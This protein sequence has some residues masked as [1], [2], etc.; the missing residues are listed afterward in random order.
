MARSRALDRLVLESPV[1]SVKTVSR[2][3]SA[4]A[5]AFIRRTKTRIPP[6]EVRANAWAARFSLDISARCKSSPRLSSVPT[7]SR[8]RLPFSVSTSSCEIMMTSSICNLASLS[9]RP[10]ISLVSD[11]MGSTAFSF[12]LKR[13]SRVS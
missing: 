2:M 11:A 7:L 4:C 6:G 12:L 8:D 1:G 10:V 9:T 3:P 5:L 13:I